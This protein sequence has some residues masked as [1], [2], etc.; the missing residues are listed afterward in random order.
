LTLNQGLRSLIYAV[1]V[2]Y[3]C[4]NPSHCCCSYSHSCHK[5]L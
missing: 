1:I 2:F 5:L 3:F 4:T